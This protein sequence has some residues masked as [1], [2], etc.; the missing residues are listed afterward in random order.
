MLQLTIFFLNSEIYLANICMADIFWIFQSI[1]KKQKVLKIFL[2]LCLN[3]RRYD[4]S[5]FVPDC[6]KRK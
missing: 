2:D 1:I 4:S 3:N 6:N 5:L